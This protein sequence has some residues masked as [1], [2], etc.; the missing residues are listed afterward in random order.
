MV[1]SSNA[2]T[3][4]QESEVLMNIYCTNTSFYYVGCLTLPH[5]RIHSKRWILMGRKVFCILPH[6]LNL[7]ETFLRGSVKSQRCLRLPDFMLRKIP[8]SHKI[9][10]QTLVLQMVWKTAAK[11]AVSIQGSLKDCDHVIIF[12][13][14]V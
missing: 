10:Y 11:I 8:K 7:S 9:I 14:C 2:Q 13:L 5:W 3:L 1:S 4:K 12:F 6:L